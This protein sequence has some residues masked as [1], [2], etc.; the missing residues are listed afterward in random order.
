MKWMLLGNFIFVALVFLSQA[1]QS[2]P[3]AQ[4]QYIYEVRCSNCH[5]ADGRGLGKEIPSLHKPIAN[6]SFWS[7]I[8]RNGQSNIVE[9]NGVRYTRNMPANTDLTAADITN[10]IN[11]IQNEWVEESRFVA[12]DSVNMWLE[13]CE[14]D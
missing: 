5:L 4:G 9:Q 1:C 3:F 10:L 2:E 7:C 12:L 14:E 11:Y 6:P 8:I 13:N